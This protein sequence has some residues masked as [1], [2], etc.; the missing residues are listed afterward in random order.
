MPGNVGVPCGRSANNSRPVPAKSQ[1]ERI[2]HTR[3]VH[4]QIRLHR[5]CEFL[6]IDGGRWVGSNSTG[7]SPSSA[8]RER[9]GVRMKPAI[10]ESLQGLP[11]SLKW[12]GA[13]DTARCKPH[14]SCLRRHLIAV[15]WSFQLAV[16]IPFR[17]RAG[18]LQWCTLAV[19]TERPQRPQLQRLMLSQPEDETD[20]LEQHERFSLKASD[21]WLRTM[22]NAE[23]G[24]GRCEP[25]A[26]NR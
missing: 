20:W 1:L 18:G 13:S 3:P 6:Q 25:R 10:G 19:G 2:A 23:N 11:V 15:N 21:G 9:A 22:G 16:D 12:K 26:S 5:S 24:A 17:W 4:I 8:I 14:Q 7:A